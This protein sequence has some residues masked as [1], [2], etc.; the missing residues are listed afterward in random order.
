MIAAP[1]TE[2]EEIALDVASSKNVAAAEVVHQYARDVVDCRIVANRYVRL[3][4]ARHL[5]WLEREDLVW[6]AEKAGRAI[7][8]YSLLKLHEGDFDGKPF[9]L[10]PWQAFVVGSACGW[11]THDPDDGELI[12]LI[13]NVY[14]ETGKGSGKTPLLAGIGGYTIIGEGVSGATAYSA[15][16]SRAQS[17]IAWH[18]MKLMIEKS[19]E[20]QKRVRTWAHSIEGPKHSAFSYLSSEAKNLH[21]PRVYRALIDEEHAHPNADV[22]DAMREGTKAFRDAQM[23]RIT[24]SGFNRHTICWQDHQY[25]IQILEGILDDDSWFGFVAGLDMCDE[26][27]ASGAPVDGCPSCDQWT[28][29]AVWPKANPSLGTTIRKQYL[30]ELVREAQGK[31]AAQSI[32]KRLNFCIWTEGSG[33]WLDAARF[34]AAADPMTPEEQHDERRRPRPLPANRRGYGGLDLSQS[35]DLTALAFV[36]PRAE[37]PIAGHA[38]RC[39]DLRVDFWLPG[40]NVTAHMKRDK[41][42]YDVWIAEGWIQTTHG[43]WIDRDAIL[44]TIVARRSRLISLGYD[45]WGMDQM[46][47]DLEAAGFDGE[48]EGWIEPI[49][50]GFASLAG[51]SKRLEDDIAKG[52]CHHDGNPVLT[53]MVANAIADEDAAGNRKPNKARSSEKIDGVSAWLDALATWAGGPGEAPELEPLLDWDDE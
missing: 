10:I 36:S 40:E 4:A 9:Q 27:R 52:F 3:L 2:V 38:G 20:L 17:F 50:Q 44:Q 49:G 21:G 39:Y 47:Q 16:P 14:V 19:P 34:V 11:Y 1:P 46:R 48:T 15:A 18:D 45:T 25:S 24:N 29:E 51:P 13:R 43:D 7:R 30:R 5:R 33:L 32:V 26:H 28:D 23:W 22:I 31:P 41:V 8:F 35:Q 42:P 12:R 6:D 37:C 53:W